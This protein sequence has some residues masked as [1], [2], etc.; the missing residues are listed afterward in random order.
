MLHSNERLHETLSLALEDRSKGYQDLV[1]NNNAI[2]YLLKKKKAWK[3]FS[4]PTIR[5]RLLYNESN[6]Y[7]R[8][9]GY[10]LLNPRPVELIND[11]EFTPKLGAVTVT[12]SG[13]EIL[14]NSG[15]NQ[16]IDLMETHI[17]AAETELQDRFTEDIHSD[18]TA[19][20]GKQ[21][22]GLD[23]AIPVVA[24]AGVYGGID[25]AA[26]PLWRTGAY[27]AAQDPFGEGVEVTSDNVRKYFS[28][29]I[30]NHTRGMRSPD[31]I[32][33][34][35]DHYLAYEASVQEIQR[36][37]DEGGLGTRGF[38][39]LKYY[40]GGKSIDVVLDSGI[41][42]VLAD[43]ESIFLDM[44]ALKFRYHPDRNFVKFGGKQMPVNQDAIVQHIG[45]YGNLTLN[46]PLFSARLK[47]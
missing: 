45:F 25:R 43:D 26:Q 12:L 17:E 6:T 11:A 2:L 16:L 15:K 42:G 31:C 22:T 30:I 23:A 21:I 46:N 19:D 10:Q 27:L 24:N 20:G 4:G 14:Q 47:G 37:T 18:G 39:S 8:Y 3:P 36:I 38:T 28:N 33:A 1:S 9:S 44:K 7:V 34:G 29:I 32:N 41:G 35:K 40:G 5:E 13:E